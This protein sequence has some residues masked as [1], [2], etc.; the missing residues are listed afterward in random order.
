[1]SQSS[2]GW[3]SKGMRFT[4]RPKATNKTGGSMSVSAYGAREALNA[5]N[6]MI[7]GGLEGVEILN[8]QGRAYD[9]AEL[10]RL[11]AEAETRQA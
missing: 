9:L 3:G 8:E 10:E 4:I 6:G 7:D 11:T 1:M 5:A 2:E